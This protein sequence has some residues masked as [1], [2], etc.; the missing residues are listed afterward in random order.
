MTKV[1]NRVGVVGAGPGGLATAITIKRVLPEL[2]VFLFEQR[3][4]IGKRDCGEALSHKA[5]VDNR[6]VLGNLPKGVIAR[7]V[8]EIVFKLGDHEER[9]SSYG[10]MIN[11]SDFNR[12]LKERAESLGCIVRTSSRVESVR[13][14]EDGWKIN[15]QD[16]SNKT[17]YKIICDV[18][19]AADGSSSVI[20]QK[21]GLITSWER[22]R[23]LR[24]HV[25]AY[26]YKIISSYND[27]ALNFDFTPDPGQEFVYHYGFY[28]HDDESNFGFLIKRTGIVD[29]NFYEIHIKKYLERMGVKYKIKDRMVGY[30]PGGGPIPKIYGDRVLAVGDAAGL[31][32]PIF[33]GGIHT[34]LSSGSVAGEVIVEA[35]QFKDFSKKV[36]K[37]YEDKCKAKPFG[38]SEILLKGKYALEKL[39][40]GQVLEPE[41]EK[42]RREAFRITKEYG[43]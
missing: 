2:E 36:L 8:K 38:K 19:V 13:R 41:E 33:Y 11:R 21:S 37:K 7:D 4:E 20:V 35:H 17:S 24:E 22:R 10:H 23:W 1:T 34:A 9:V 29:S 42:V 3:N 27:S 6:K 40:T 32:N 39:R 15:V 25:L 18:L 14:I 16:R 5:L 31:T 12:Y 43:W 28:H 30:V 26:Q